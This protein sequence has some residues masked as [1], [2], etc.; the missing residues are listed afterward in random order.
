ME[1]EGTSFI[2]GTTIVAKTG[3]RHTFMTWGAGGS[4]LHSIEGT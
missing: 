1:Y 2:S 4:A 3:M